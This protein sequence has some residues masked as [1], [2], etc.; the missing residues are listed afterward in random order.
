MKDNEKSMT[1]KYDDA[2]LTNSVIKEGD[3]VEEPSRWGF[4]PE[5]SPNERKRLPG[6]L[7]KQQNYRWQEK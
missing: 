7:L 2:E 1:G 4:A 5:Y 6:F 3:V